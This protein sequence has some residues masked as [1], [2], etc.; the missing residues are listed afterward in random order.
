MAVTL[1]FDVYGTLIDTH[2]VVT[3]LAELVPGDPRE[4]S[5]TWRSKQIEYSF[6][7][8]LMQNFEDFSVCTRDALEYACAYHQVSIPPDKKRLLLAIY[9]RLPAFPEVKEAITALA[10]ASYTMFAFSNGS[11]EAIEGLLTH[12]GIRPYFAGV[13]STSDLKSF[14]PNPAV[15]AYFLRRANALASA[16]YLISSNPFDVIGARS[17]GLGAIW[18]QRSPNAIFDPWGIDPSLVI[19]N[20]TALPKSLGS[21]DAGQ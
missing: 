21:L 2:G 15:Y 16:A 1:A 4:F 8:A 20:L 13:V 6:R 12:A 19:H 17:A 9:R 5:N 14:K 10:D 3:Q 11:Q 7:R 18:V